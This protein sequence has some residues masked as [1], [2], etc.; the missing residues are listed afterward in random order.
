MGNTEQPVA[1]RD[2]DDMETD[3]REKSIEEN[4]FIGNSIIRNGIAE[5]DTE[6]NNAEEDDIKGNVLP[7]QREE[8]LA[9]A[10]VVAEPW[11]SRHAEREERK[12]LTR[13]R[14]RSASADNAVL[15]KA[16]QLS[17]DIDDNEHKV[18][19]YVRV[20]TASEE[21]V[22]SYEN[23]KKYYTEKVTRNPKWELV[24]IYADEGKSGTS[25]KKRT[26]FLRM[27]ED[28]RNQKIDLILCASVSRFARN[29]GD[30][31][32]EIQ[33][34]QTQNPRHPV[35]VFFE[36]EHLNTLN[37]DAGVNLQVHAMLADWESANKSRRMILSYDQRIC[38]GQYPLSDLLG[39][40]HTQDGRLVMVED[41]AVTVKYIFMAR[42]S[43]QSNEEIAET[44]TEY[45]RPTLKGRTD[46]NAGMVGA[47]LLNERR[48][49]DLMAR[50]TVV[51]NYKE[52]KV[53]KNEKIRDAAFV[54][55]HHEGIVTPEIAK[56]VHLLTSSRLRHTAVP[57]ISVIRAG[58]L[59][60]FVSLNPSF[61]GIDRDTILELSRSAYDEEEYEDVE[62]QSRVI[63]GE[64]HSKIIHMD[65]NGYYVPYSA[66][67]IGRETPTLTISQKQI[68]FNRKCYE[69]LGKCDRIELLYHP[70]LQ[71][72]VIR[73][74]DDEEGFP[75]VNE[76][77]NWIPSFRGEAFCGAV[78]EELDWIKEYSFR[79]RGITRER[80]SRKIMVFYLDEP[81]V[82]KT[83][84][85]QKAAEAVEAEQADLPSRYIPI[86]YS[87]LAAK[88]ENGMRHGIGMLYP[89]RK[90]RDSLF[91][92]LTAADAEEHGDVVVNP[93]IGYIPSHE[94]VEEELEAL[95]MS[96]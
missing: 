68:K 59:K 86:K 17:L 18:G 64:E 72:V 53:V 24:D 51:L 22:S 69:R 60:G 31:V 92:S 48:W 75:W 89:F 38:T 32:N 12:K 57:E 91:N 84:A 67:F 33:K 80:G 52:Q 16:D 88:E 14:I 70:L 47:I 65:F 76:N 63:S 61:N 93:L 58:G 78:Y 26:E 8:D 55:N 73:N 41:E 49:G 81:Q 13:E 42:L 2:T 30:F 82:V 3:V 36:T 74:C 11:N 40:R 35:G 1:E 37:P 45:Q 79:F 46:W 95:L 56:A 62:Y 21:Q 20:S 23:Q 85:S 6:E 15:I 96:M 44:L 54:E 19:V 9:V 27:L 90:K 83:K 43:G 94:S 34:L 50:K 39:Y 10:E 87:E 66:F 29:V 5:N 77:G 7:K 71:A 4:N 25:M 28:A